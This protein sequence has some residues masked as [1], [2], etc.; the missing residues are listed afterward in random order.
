MLSPKISLT[1]AGLELVNSKR[2]DEIFLRQFL[3]FQVPSPYH[4]PSVD[5]AKFWV[6]P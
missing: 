6:K 5:A 4:K 3:K 2:K 1:P